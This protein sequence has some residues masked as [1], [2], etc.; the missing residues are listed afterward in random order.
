MTDTGTI[1]C[2]SFAGEERRVPPCRDIEHIL[3]DRM[4]IL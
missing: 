2:L 3:S 1:I 4:A